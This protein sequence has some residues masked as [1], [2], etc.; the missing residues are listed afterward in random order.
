MAEISVR[1]SPVEI[2]SLPKLT[3]CLPGVRIV[4]EFRSSVD[5][6]IKSSSTDVFR[7]ER[8]RDDR[9]R[10]SSTLGI[11]GSLLLC[12]SARTSYPY[13]DA[14]AASSPYELV[15][16]LAHRIGVPVERGEPTH[17]DR[18]AFTDTSSTSASPPTVALV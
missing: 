2:Q 11:E 17:K 13:R 6:E 8:P 14:L 4:L 10:L 5:S 15:H 18:R 3:E 9:A 1:P 16:L 12:G 7:I